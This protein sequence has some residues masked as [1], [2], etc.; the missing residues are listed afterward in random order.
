ME[1]K[2]RSF[3][4]AVVRK[5]KEELWR[6]YW[7]YSKTVGT[8]EDAPSDLGRVEIVEAGTLEEAIDDVQASHPDCTVMLAG[9]EHHA[10]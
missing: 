2:M 1:A 10:A 3:K 7:I 6:K 5:G 8:A 4:L 9:G